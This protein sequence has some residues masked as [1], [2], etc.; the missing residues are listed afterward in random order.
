MYTSKSQ[1]IFHSNAHKSS[2][3]SQI[4]HSK[5]KEPLLEFNQLQNHPDHSYHSFI[6]GL[7]DDCFQQPLSKQDKI[8]IN[9][10]GKM[11]A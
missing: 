4:N 2:I 8:F 9:L 11:E 3:I 10:I 1:S 7:K 5:I 6:Y